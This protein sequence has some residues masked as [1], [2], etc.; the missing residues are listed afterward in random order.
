M[1]TGLSEQASLTDAQQCDIMSDHRIL[2]I[3]VHGKFTMNYLL[4]P[5]LIVLLFIAAALLG[6]RLFVE[7]DMTNTQRNTL[8]PQTLQTLQSLPHSVSAEVFINPQ[9]QQREAIATL[10]DN[11]L[12]YTSDAADE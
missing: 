10:L 9:D 8:L 2:N 6:N 11:C 12:L 4:R 1:A 7:R 5:F 3:L